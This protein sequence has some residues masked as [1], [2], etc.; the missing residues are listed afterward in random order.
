MALL[1]ATRASLS[2]EKLLC[3]EGIEY[4]HLTQEKE[5]SARVA[6]TADSTRRICPDYAGLGAG[7]SEELKVWAMVEVEFDSGHT[8]EGFEPNESLLILR[9]LYGMRPCSGCSSS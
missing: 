3:Y 2:S 4:R 5:T 9:H 1:V 6:Y 7:F 8:R